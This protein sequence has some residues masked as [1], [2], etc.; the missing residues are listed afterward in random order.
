M[1]NIFDVVVRACMRFLSGFHDEKYTDDCID[2]CMFHTSFFKLETHRL[3]SSPN[4]TLLKQR[5]ISEKV[6]FGLKET[7]WLNLSIRVIYFA[8]ISFSINSR[9]LNLCYLTNSGLN[10]R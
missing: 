7:K 3:L 1:Y 9:F 8:R 6:R 2:E 4:W 5:N 10:I